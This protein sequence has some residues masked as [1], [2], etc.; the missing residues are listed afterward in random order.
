V[1]LQA[2]L[3]L[4]CPGCGGSSMGLPKEILGIVGWEEYCS[5]NSIIPFPFNAA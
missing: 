4:T 2:T 1:D 3:R 5:F